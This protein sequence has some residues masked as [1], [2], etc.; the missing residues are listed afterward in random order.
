MHIMMMTSIGTTIAVVK[1][2]WIGLTPS[3]LACWKCKSLHSSD[4]LSS[5]ES[6]H[7][8]D[9]SVTSGMVSVCTCVHMCYQRFLMEREKC[10]TYYQVFFLTF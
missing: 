6:E 4:G 2:G 9:P 10:F 5:Q 7:L 3:P 1:I 8:E